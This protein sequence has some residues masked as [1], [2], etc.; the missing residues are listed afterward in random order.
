MKLRYTPAALAELVAVLDTIAE[1]SPTGAR[2]VQARIKAMTEL[3]LRHPHAGQSTNLPGLRRIAATPYP[4][5]LFYEPHADE[6]IVIGIRHAAR[7][8]AS[9]PDA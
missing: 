4:Y 3:L 1:Q 6:V 7:D 9:M 8:P 2:R 5:V